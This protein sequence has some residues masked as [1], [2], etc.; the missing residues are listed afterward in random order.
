MPVF[1][2]TTIWLPPSGGFLIS[3]MVTQSLIVLYLAVLC[4]PL[5]KMQNLD[6]QKSLDVP[7]DSLIYHL[8][9][10]DYMIQIKSLMFI[11]LLKPIT[12]NEG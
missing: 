8:D 9:Q 7:N 2:A 4:S 3:L 6:L 11:T 10:L 1:V 5:Q 12:L